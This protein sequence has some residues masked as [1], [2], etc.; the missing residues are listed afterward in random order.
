M[1]GG[2]FETIPADCDSPCF[3]EWN[4][5][6]EPWITQLMKAKLTVSVQDFFLSIRKLI[7]LT[8]AFKL[9]SVSQRSK[10]S[11]LLAYVKATINLKKGEKNLWFVRGFLFKL[12]PTTSTLH[13]KLCVPFPLGMSVCKYTRFPWQNYELWFFHG[14]VS[15]TI[16]LLYGSRVDFDSCYFSFSPLVQRKERKRNRPLTIILETVISALKK[17]YI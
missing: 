10:A 6:L 17:L 5:Y 11:F 15:K 16:P 4:Y 3:E 2:E 9:K 13:Y 12:F 1:P 8:N 7:S 14:K